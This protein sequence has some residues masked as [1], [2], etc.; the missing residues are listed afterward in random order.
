MRRLAALTVVA[1]LLLAPALTALGE[2]ASYEDDFSEVSYSGNDGSIE[3]DE[4]WE[5]FGD[6]G[7]PGSGAVHVGQEN[8]TKNK[9]LHIEGSGLL[10]SSLGID[11]YA[12]T[13]VFGSA[14]LRYDITVDAFAGDLG[15]LLVEVWNGSGWVLIDSYHLSDSLPKKTR[16]LP[17]NDYLWED[18]AVRFKVP[19]LFEG[20]PTLFTGDIA[21]DEVEIIG[22]QT[23]PT[24]TTTTTSST[25]TTTEPTTT[26]TQPT[27]TT[28]NSDTTTT[29]EPD[30]TTTGGD[31]TVTTEPGTTST[32]APTTTTLPVTTTTTAGDTT[33]SVAITGVPS[34]GQPPPAIFEGGIRDT[35]TGIAV[36][37]HEGMNGDMAGLDQVEVLSAEVT[38]DFSLAVESIKAAR[39]WVAA[40]G[41][42]IAGA[43]VSGMD[44]R[45]KTKG[46]AVLSSA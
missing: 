34:D 46:L 3:F 38:T 16:N 28:T 21:I 8:C 22:A 14:Q 44:H 40:L 33:T 43:L 39:I 4:P 19:G 20:S 32:T 26:T 5:E 10:T 41:L 42:M 13:S 2:T 24:T 37:Y 7:G 25:T 23:A 45:R 1:L 29:T 31:T 15:E 6:D 27:T 17:L 35:G 36:D 18:F 12:D 11:R 30:T 9:C